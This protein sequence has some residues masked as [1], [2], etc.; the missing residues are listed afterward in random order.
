[1][2]SAGLA[3]EW[4]H[5]LTPAYYR[6]LHDIEEQH[7]WARGMRALAAE[8]LG[9]LIHGQRGAR[10]LDAGCGTGGMLAWLQKAGANSASGI[11][12]SRDALH[13]CQDRGQRGLALGSALALPYLDD[14]FDVVLST[15]VI[16]HLPDPPGDHLALV[17]A[18]RVL[19]PGG[20]LYVRTNS[21]FGIGQPSSR[22]PTDYRRY[23]LGD[24]KARTRA[25]GFGV[26][27]A[28]YAN[29][30]PS[31]LA[32]GRRLWRG[33]QVGTQ[34][35]GLRVLVRPP[36]LRWLDHALYAV[37]RLEAWRVGKLKRDLPFGHSIVILARK[38]GDQIGG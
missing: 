31:L 33:G 4:P 14:T 28:S 18:Y 35:A 32:V 22:Q 20:Y 10:I 21:S 12:I 37:L 8:L 3:A 25:A 6:R 24:L 19:R 11:D 16:Q 5:V 27:R 2:A 13:F 29:C 1:M 38:P 7:G 26:L 23:E 30:L 15:D 34:D 17:E 9:P 36:A